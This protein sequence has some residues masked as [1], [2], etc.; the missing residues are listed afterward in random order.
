M[1]REERWPKAFLIAAGVVLAAQLVELFVLPINFFTFRAWEALA[2][3]RLHFA[4]P[5]PFYPESRVVMDEDGDLAP[6]TELAVKKHVEFVTDRFGFRRRDSA[7]DRWDAV[8]VGDSHTAG[9]TLTQDDTLPE[10]VEKLAALKVYPLA[11]ATMDFFLAYDRFRQNPPKTVVL[12]LAESFIADG[13]PAD[14]ADFGEAQSW[15]EDLVRPVLFPHPSLA[16]I[17]DRVA[18]GV[19]YFNAS[20]MVKRAMKHVIGRPAPGVKGAMLFGDYP[21]VDEARAD[22]IVKRMLFYRDALKARGIRFL[23][24]PIPSKGT[25]Y[26]ELLPSQTTQPQSLAHLTTKLRAAG[27]EVVDVLSALR[28][29]RK[30]HPDE[31]LFHTDDSHW[32]PRGCQVAAELLAR[33]LDAKAGPPKFGARH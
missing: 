13:V 22:D 23:F 25:L 5:G 17:C 2:V 12:E 7:D 27:I 31:L 29:A 11:P 15:E 33:A 8:L 18:K 16:V 30:A 26:W 3:R 10:K 28:S 6:H 32:N 14:S 1:S 19:I 9:A 24:M 20:A 21:P 4:L